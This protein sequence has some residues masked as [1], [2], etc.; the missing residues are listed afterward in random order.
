MKMQIATGLV[1]IAGLSLSGLAQRSED[2]DGVDSGARVSVHARQFGV[3]RDLG[4]SPGTDN[5]CRVFYRPRPETNFRGATREQDLDHAAAL[6][7][8]DRLYLAQQDG[9]R[10]NRQVQAFAAG[11]Q[12]VH[13]PLPEPRLAVDDRDGF[14]QA[15]TVVKTAVGSADL[16][17]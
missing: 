17:A 8:A 10:R 1:F 4:P 2:V 12:P 6:P 16:S 3:A 5:T 15:V 9:L 13:V 14:E 11:G 7:C